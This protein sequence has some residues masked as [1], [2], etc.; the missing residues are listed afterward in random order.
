MIDR[1]NERIADLAE[2]FERGQRRRKL[3]GRFG[4]VDEGW[5]A[6]IIG[7]NL[8]GASQRYGCIGL[9]GDASLKLKAFVDRR[10]RR[11][12]EME[13]S[14]TCGFSTRLPGCHCERPSTRRQRWTCRGMGVNL[15]NELRNRPRL[16]Q[17][18]ANGIADKIVQK[19]LLAKTDFCLRRMHVDVDFAGRHLKEQQDHWENGG[20]QDV[21]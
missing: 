11:G 18:I 13:A 15:R 16:H 7:N 6:A 9:D 10:R 8:R 4:F 1:Q 3:A 20:W 19:G 21:A 17:G 5:R 2:W 12:L 14:G